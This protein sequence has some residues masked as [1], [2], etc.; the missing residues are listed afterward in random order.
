MRVVTAAEMAELDRRA[1]EEFGVPA[2]ALM[3]RAGHHVATVVSSM[4]S[5]IGG[6]RVAVLAGKGNNGGDGFV[7]ARYLRLAGLEVTAFLLAEPDHLKGDVAA[8]LGAAKEAGVSTQALPSDIQPEEL[9]AMFASAGILIDAIFGTGFHG[10]IEGLPA[11]VVEAANRSGK[12]ILAVDIPSG[13]LADTGQ[14][15]GPHIRAVA[16]VTL[17]MPK[18]GLLVYPGAEAVGKLYVADIG[19]P[20]VLM[21]AP[22]PGTQLVTATMVRTRFPPRPL[23]SHKGRY[24]RVL[25]IG[26]SVGFSGAAA[27]AA[28]GA[29]RVGAGL[30]TVGVPASIYPIVASKLTEAM[31]T[32][33]PA[34]DGAIAAGSLDQ[35]KA[36]AAASDVIGVGPGLSRD[37]GA[38]H[39]VTG[40]L[41]VDRPLVID[42]DGLNVLV[43]K[44]HFLAQ[45]RKPVVITPHPG[46]LSRL[47]AVPIATIQED[48]L[49][50][51]RTAAKRFNCI[52]VLKGA[53]TIVAEPGGDAFLIP[54]GNPGMAT[55]GMGDV[56]TGAIV[57]LMGQRM[58]PIEAAYSGAYLHGLAAD[59]IASSRGLVGML[60][61]E[62]A[63]HLPI[64]IHRVRAGE[65]VDPIQLLGTAD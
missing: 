50:A 15:S 59:L 62:V 60:A 39:V 14:S 27:L 49:A 4:L 40:L 64:A 7:A 2:S 21:D 28:L 43:G 9:M 29:L 12:P 8:A 42:A 63:D 11:T 53:R 13:L 16:T 3:D 1:T 65:Q 58:T 41:G 38:V 31:P 23:D 24:G 26:G 48:R 61:S 17:G 37:F 5:A 44:T 51:A 6:R 54:T 55:G 35:V 56:L 36:L 22:T 30:V 57:G 34:S 45:A 19:Y 18:Y 33:L 25:I 46:E 32:P 52:V 10:V 47:T 20:S